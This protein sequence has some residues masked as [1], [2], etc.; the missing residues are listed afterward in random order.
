M[1]ISHAIQSINHLITS[2]GGL[3]PPPAHHTS[4]GFNFGK[5]I[6]NIL[7]PLHLVSRVTRIGNKAVNTAEHAV[8]VGLDTAG[9]FVDKGAKNAN[10]LLNAGSNLLSFFSSPMGIAIVGG[11]V[12]LVVL[13]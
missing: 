3:K 2:G 4:S 5:E 9:N 1:Y 11:V 8:D 6:S 10:K 7:D 12:L 13:K